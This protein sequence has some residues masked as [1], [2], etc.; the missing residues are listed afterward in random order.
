[1]KDGILHP[2]FER[3]DGLVLYNQ[4][5]VPRSLQKIVLDNVH[6][7]A[8]SGHYGVQKTQEKLQKYA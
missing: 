2:R 5:I 4:L 7:D 6:A 3:P 8:M 1:M